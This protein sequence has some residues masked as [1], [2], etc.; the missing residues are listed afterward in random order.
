MGFWK[1]LGIGKSTWITRM[2]TPYKEAILDELKSGVI[3]E[4]FVLMHGDGGMFHLR[5]RE[6]FTEDFPTSNRK[7]EINNGKSKRSD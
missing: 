7:K 1:R 2:I 4:E 5:V 6:Y 3:D